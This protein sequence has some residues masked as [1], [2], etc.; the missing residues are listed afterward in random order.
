M[1]PMKFSMAE[2]WGMITLLTAAFAAL[3]FLYGS[4]TA[5]AG[6]IVLSIPVH[7]MVCDMVEQM[8]KARRRRKRII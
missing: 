8:S 3:R 2:F 4:P 5:L 7:A 1:K 6:I